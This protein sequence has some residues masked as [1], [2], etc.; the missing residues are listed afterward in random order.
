M[1]I[2]DWDMT[3]VKGGSGNAYKG[4][5]DNQTVF[6]KRNA[7]PLLTSIYL[8][9]IT[10]KV[11]WNKRTSTGDMLS[12]QPWIEGH[13]LSTS[14]MSDTQINQIL[15]HLHRSQKLVDSYKKLGNRI[16]GP[17]EL[18]NQLVEEAPVVSNNRYLVDIIEEM[19]Q[20]LPVFYEREATVVHGDVNHRNWLKDEENGKIYLVDWDIAFLG[21]P[22]IDVAYILVHYIS[23]GEWSRWLSYSG[24]QSYKRILE[25]IFWYGKLSFLRQIAEYLKQSNT[26]GANQEIL[27]LRKFC[28]YEKNHKN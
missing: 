12:A 7:S 13:T 28:E 23:P 10:P 24:F 1:M 20:N 8:E 16:Y 25:K 4:I 21:D 22:M 6:I 9:G 18:L 3:P 27:W 2:S 11:L 26:Q 19:R 5:V 15:V 17:E 14:E